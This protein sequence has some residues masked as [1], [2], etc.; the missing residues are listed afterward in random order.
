MK[1]LINLWRFTPLRRVLNMKNRI[2][3]LGIIAIFVTIGFSM[4][5]CGTKGGTLEIINSRSQTIKVTVSINP[6]DE[7]VTKTINA[8]E[9]ETW[10]ISENFNCGVSASY[11]NEDGS[12]GN[13]F[14]GTKW[15]MV[16]NGEKVTITL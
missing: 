15:H 4:I 5:S 7:K 8:G 3:F 16:R 12:V 1:F 10:D 2:K 11:V 14:Y 6:A 9:K 13:S